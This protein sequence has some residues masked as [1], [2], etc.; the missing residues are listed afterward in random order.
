MRAHA[1]S[2]VFKYA[3][4]N[5]LYFTCQIRLCQKQMGNCQGVT[6]SSIIVDIYVIDSH[7]DVQPIVHLMLIIQHH[8][9]IDVDDDQQMLMN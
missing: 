6:V 8:H 1:Q 3:D 7:L 4:S 5:Q 9:L 2:Q